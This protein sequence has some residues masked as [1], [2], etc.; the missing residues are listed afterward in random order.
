LEQMRRG[1]P[2]GAI[3]PGMQMPGEPGPRG[4]GT[5]QYL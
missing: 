3:P 4:T 2:A 1:L 5:G